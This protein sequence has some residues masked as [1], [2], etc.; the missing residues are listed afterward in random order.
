LKEFDKFV[1]G[2]DLEK[3]ENY[4]S[5]VKNGFIKTEGYEEKMV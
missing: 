5:L 1:S 3:L 4:D 2:K